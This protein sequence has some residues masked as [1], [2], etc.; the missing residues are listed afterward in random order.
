[1]RRRTGRRSA[2]PRESGAWPS[3]ATENDCHP[4]RA[5][6]AKIRDRRVNSALPAVPDL[7]PASLGLSGMTTFSSTRFFVVSRPTTTAPQPSP[8]RPRSPPP[9]A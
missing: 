6:S 1:M 7:R 9:G 3:R 5:R 8:H 2:H 4:G